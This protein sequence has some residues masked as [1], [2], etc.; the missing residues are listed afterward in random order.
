MGNSLNNC[1]PCDDGYRPKRLK[2]DSN[3]VSYSDLPD[4]IRY[5]D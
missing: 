5:N 4:M 1:M 2:A 3:V